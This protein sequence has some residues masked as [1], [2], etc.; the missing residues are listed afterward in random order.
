[1]ASFLNESNQPHLELM[2]I[3][4]S[5]MVYFGV[6]I[7]NFV[8]SP[9]IC[10]PSSKS[11]LFGLGITMTMFDFIRVLISRIDVGVEKLRYDCC[12]QSFTITAAEI[13]QSQIY[14]QSYKQ[15]QMISQEDRHFG[16]RKI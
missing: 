10:R 13:R 6:E 1:M 8:L 4:G 7:M 11:Y 3:F 9:F 14:W 5:I 15:S 12:N 2:V 16:W